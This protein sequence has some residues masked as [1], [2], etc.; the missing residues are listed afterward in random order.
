MNTQ[1]SKAVVVV[2]GFDAVIQDPAASPIRGLNVKFKDG[3]YFSY[4]DEIDVSGRAFGVLDRLDG[5][6]KLAKE[7]PPEYL[8][9][10]PGEAR[11]QQPHV[12]KK[13][14]P[15]NL[16]GVPEHPWKWTHYLCLLDAATGEIM[17]FW[18]NTVGGEIA[19]NQL[20]DQIAIMRRVRSDAVPVVA[21]ETK[22]MPGTYKKPRPHFQLLGWKTR[23]DLGPQN[24]LAGPE[25]K[26][27]DPMCA[28]EP[29]TS[30]E[31]FSDEIPY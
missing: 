18:T 2:D 25:Q 6:Q 9:Q 21:L 29:P 19:V 23:N 5:W 26:H 12:D 3:S 22:N 16:N 8:M 27:A 31:L 10:K 28:V 7:A 14:W 4:A 24:L 20:T 11:P 30:A 1:T 17:T 15:K 13:H